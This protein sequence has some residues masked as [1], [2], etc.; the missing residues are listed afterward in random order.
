MAD[1]APITSNAEGVAKTGAAVPML[2]IER[3][4]MDRV[5]H[6]QITAEYVITLCEITADK[7]R[8]FAKLLDRTMGV[9]GIGAFQE[10]TTFSTLLDLAVTQAELM[11]QVSL[12]AEHAAMNAEKVA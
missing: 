10:W 12:D 11:K 4:T 1:R 6:L 2:A 5:A 8:D 9:Q 7:I 3:S